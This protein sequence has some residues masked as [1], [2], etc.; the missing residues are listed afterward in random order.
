M[1]GEGRWL[2]AIGVDSGERCNVSRRLSLLK[3]MS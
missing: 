2:A 1:R 3:L